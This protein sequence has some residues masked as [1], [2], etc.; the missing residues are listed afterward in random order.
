MAK[1]STHYVDGFVLVIPKKNLAKYRTMAKEGAK[2]W[3]KH[4]AIDYKECMGDDLTPN[5][6][7]AP[8]L[9]FPKMI[10]AKKDETVWFSYITFKS[11]AHRDQVNKKVM[12]EMSKNYE[13]KDMT[14]PFDMKKTAIGG[15]K[16]VVSG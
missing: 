9:T 11:R 10:G 13:G 14:M 12:A 7:G 8:M 4:G 6:G 2:A 1:N 15:F 3:M 5:M 16:V